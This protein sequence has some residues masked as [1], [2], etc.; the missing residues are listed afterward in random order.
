M[1]MVFKELFLVLMCHCCRN[2]SIIYSRNGWAD[3]FICIFLFWT[4]CPYVLQICSDVLPLAGLCSL[5]LEPEQHAHS[6]TVSACSHQCRH[7][8][9]EGALAVRRDVLLLLLLAYRRPLELFH[10]LPALVRAVL[11]ASTLH[12]PVCFREFV[13]YFRVPLHTEDVCKWKAKCAVFLAVAR[14][15]WI[16]MLLWSIVVGSRRSI[17]LR[18]TQDKQ[19]SAF[20]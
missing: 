20:H 16:Q 11:C 7:L 1:T 9:H 12:C 18:Q 15:N 6:G 10:Q 5:W 17:Q 13:F 2:F 4:W 3:V 19:I 8:W 14:W